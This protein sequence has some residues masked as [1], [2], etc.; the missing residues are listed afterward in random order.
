MGLYGPYGRS[1]IFTYKS[2]PT[3][4]KQKVI[5][6][7]VMVRPMRPVRQ[8]E[9]VRQDSQVRH[10]R[11]ERLL[12]YVRLVQFIPCTHAESSGLASRPY[13]SG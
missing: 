2:C 6:L 5:H 9:H 10:V 11:Q 1:G 8:V 7:S 3:N 4:A 12:R 13:E